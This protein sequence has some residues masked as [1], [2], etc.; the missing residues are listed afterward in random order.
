MGSVRRL[1]RKSTVVKSNLAD[2]KYKSMRMSS[3]SYSLAHSL[4][5][6]RRIR[7]CIINHTIFWAQSY[8]SVRCGQIVRLLERICRNVVAFYQKFQWAPLTYRTV[9]ACKLV[10]LYLLVTCGGYFSNIF[11]PFDTCDRPKPSIE[12]QQ[13]QVHPSP[14][15]RCSEAVN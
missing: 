5:A 10:A 6:F 8:R 7:I 13:V 2:I 11:E 4:P 14:W 15:T 1:I 9:L 12:A 3:P